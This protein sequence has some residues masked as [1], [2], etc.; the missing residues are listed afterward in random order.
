MYS[1]LALIRFSGMF[2]LVI[3]KHFFNSAYKHPPV[4][5]PTQNPIW[6]DIISQ[7]L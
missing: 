2:Y 3:P 5:K 7:G 1:M 4:Y 6:S